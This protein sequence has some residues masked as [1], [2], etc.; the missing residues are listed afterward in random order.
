MR[1]GIVAIAL[2]LIGAAAP[3][4]YAQQAQQQQ[5]PP[6]P[7]PPREGTAEF[8]FVGTSGNASTN[9]LGLG[10]EYIARQMP[11][12]FR[13]KAV[14]VRNESEDVLKA[15]SFTTIVRAQR[16]LRPRLSAFG[17]YGYLHDVF[18]GIDARNTIEGGL[19]FALI[20][21]QPHQLDVDGGFGYANE[22]RVIGDDLSSA[23]V[24]TG[25]RYVFTLSDTAQITDDL[26]FSSSLADGRDWRTANIAAV[27]AKLTTVLSLK[28]SSTVRYVHAPP[29]DF[30][31][32]DT[33]TAM[34]LVAK[35]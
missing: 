29:D 10:A 17:Q 6:P 8:S 35:F 5:Q 1:P 14:Y 28:L 32:T 30:E 12:E 15:E 4:G 34:A 20:R 33:I 21:P 23:Q 18:A 7:P 24:F 13:G 31:T 9:A 27:T 11:W 16:T 3:F 22:Q 25:A 19:S 26:R 2:T